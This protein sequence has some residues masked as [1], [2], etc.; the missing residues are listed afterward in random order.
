MP[1]R[2]TAEIMFSWAYRVGPPCRSK[3]FTTIEQHKID[4]ID[5]FLHPLLLLKEVAGRTWR[6]HRLSGAPRGRQDD[7]EPS[8]RPCSQRTLP[9]RLPPSRPPSSSRPCWESQREYVAPAAVP[10]MYTREREMQEKYSTHAYDIFCI[11]DVVSISNI[12]ARLGL[13]SWREGVIKK[14]RKKKIGRGPGQ[15]EA[16]GLIILFCQVAWVPQASIT[17]QTC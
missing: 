16:V 7:T 3:S 17:P 13:K 1:R 9:D 8:R 6:N 4:V 15:G 11:A 2:V 14:K 10:E 5:Q 12:Y